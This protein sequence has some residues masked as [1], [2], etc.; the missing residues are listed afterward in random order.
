MGWNK[1]LRIMKKNFLLIILFLSFILNVSANE[2]EEVTL[3]KCVDGDTAIFNVN[4]N[5]EKFRFLAIDT[6]ESVHPTKKVES[7]GKEASNFTCDLL[8]NAKTIK[9]EFDKNSDKKDKYGRYLAW[10]YVDDVMIQKILLEK[11]LAKIA[12]IYGKYDY[13]DELYK[14]QNEASKNKIG[15]WSKEKNEYTVTFKSYKSTKN[16]KV[17]ANSKITK[18]E[19]SKKNGY[20]FK[21]W[22]YND[23]EYNFDNNVNSNITLTAKYEKLN[24]IYFLKNKKYKTIIIILILLILIYSPKKLKKVLKKL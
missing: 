7:F 19:A 23:K 3:K 22:M 2:T 20:I 24:L 14:I 10:V 17:L 4:D 16:I 9:I 1:L 5:E 15:I 8:K 12:Y 13:M 6:P 18:I 21:Y 11:G